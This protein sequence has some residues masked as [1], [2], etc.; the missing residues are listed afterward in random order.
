MKKKTSTHVQKSPSRLAGRSAGIAAEFVGGDQESDEVTELQFFFCKKISG[1][2][3]PS[4][5]RM[6]DV[7][8]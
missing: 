1:K 8:W 3:K 4:K 5:L 7:A 6:K 2:V